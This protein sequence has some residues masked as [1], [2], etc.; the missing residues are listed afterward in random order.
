MESGDYTIVGVNDEYR[1]EA[2]SA[3]SLE[4]FEFDYAEEER[5][6]QRLTTARQARSKSDAT[7]GLRDIVKTARADGNLMP[8]IL[9]AVASGVTEGEIMGALRDEWG[10]YVDPGVF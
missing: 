7:A 6:I 2:A 1:D 5:Q 10:E 8:S 9:A 4:L 3:G